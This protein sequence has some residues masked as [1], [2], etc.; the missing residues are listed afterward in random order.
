[1][2]VLDLFSGIG[3]FSLGL[4]RAGMRTVAFCEISR[5][6]S[7]VLE[8][9]WPGV[10]NL[11]DV[12]SAEFPAA[13]IITAGF[14]CQDISSAGNRTER[15]ELAGARSGLFW[16]VIRAVR[17]V[18]PKFVILENVAILLARGALTSAHPKP[19]KTLQE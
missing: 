2:N 3:G 7:R 11:G 5:S 10:P 16:E 6:C 17:L 19:L 18:R 12:C 4:E 13:D 8:E 1:M 9:R 14:P 15:A